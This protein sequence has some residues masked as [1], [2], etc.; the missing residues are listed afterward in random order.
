ML[1]LNFFL[2]NATI[3]L[4][5]NFSKGIFPCGADALRFAFLKYNLNALDVNINIVESSEEGRRFCNKLWNLSKY[6]QKIFKASSFN[7]K[8]NSF[9]KLNNIEVFLFYFNLKLI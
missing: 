7:C 9:K 2:D 8:N 4:K 1:F 3:D 6:V 5:K